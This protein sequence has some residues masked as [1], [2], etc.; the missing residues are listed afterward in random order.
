M[1]TSTVDADASGQSDLQASPAQE[2]SPEAEASQENQEAE[3]PTPTP[4]PSKSSEAPPKKSAPQKAQEAKQSNAS[5]GKT[6]TDSIIA[7]DENRPEAG[8][9][10]KPV[11]QI[12]SLVKEL[13]QHAENEDAEKIKDISAQ[14]VQGWA[15]MKG[16]VNASYPEMTEFLQ[17]KIDSLNELHSAESL[18]SEALLQLDY[19]LYQAFRQ[20]ADKAGL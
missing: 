5:V 6:V 7:K 13:K 4:S 9:L 15:D 8:A 1:P 18:D 12:R 16:D 17:E 11:E 19:E 14:I 2:A 20:L 10:K 3:S